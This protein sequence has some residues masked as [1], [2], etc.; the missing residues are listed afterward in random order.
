M[1]HPTLVLFK[2]DWYQSKPPGS[3][4]QESLVGQFFA[5][6]NPTPSLF[7][8]MNLTALIIT[9]ALIKVKKNLK[10]QRHLNRELTL[11]TYLELSRGQLKTLTAYGSI[12]RQDFE[13]GVS[14]D[15]SMMLLFENPE[16]AMVIR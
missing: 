9:N 5:L 16:K 14:Q 4:S 8:M 3:R 2:L 10:S 6:K 15:I 7:H 1:P 12:I 13:C 11:P